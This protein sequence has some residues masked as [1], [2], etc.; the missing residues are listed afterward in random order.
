MDVARALR[1]ARQEAGLSQRQVA[2]LAD[3]PASTIGRIERGQVSPTVQML[4][5]L[6]GAMGLRLSMVFA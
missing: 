6:A 4:E 5:R 2:E 3:V 1:S